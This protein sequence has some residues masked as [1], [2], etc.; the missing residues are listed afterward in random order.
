MA[1]RF[2]VGGSGNWSDTAHWSA[3][4]GGAGGVSVPGGA[5]DVFF[6]A[7]SGTGTA[8]V[9]AAR[10]ID[11]LDC[12]GYTGA[13]SVSGGSITA[14]G[15]ADVFKLAAGMTWSNSAGVDINVS[16]GTITLTCAGKDFGPLNKLGTGG[17]TFADA[18]TT[19]GTVTHSAGTITTG[20][21]NHS[22]SH[23][24]STGAT[25]RTITC[26]SSGKLTISGSWTVS[27]SNWSI[28]CAAGSYTLEWTAALAT[29][30]AGGFNYSGTSNNITLTIPTPLANTISGANSQFGPVVVANGSALTSGG[31]TI[32]N[33]MVFRK[34]TWTGC[35]QT[36]TLTGV[37]LTISDTTTPLVVSGISAS[38]RFR[39]LNGTL[40]M[41]A[42]GTGP[43]I[44]V[45]YVNVDNNTVTRWNVGD[46]TKATCGST[47][48]GTTPNWMIEWCATPS[49]SLGI[50][51]TM[52]QGLAIAVAKSDDLGL[53]DSME[54]SPGQTRVLTDALGITDVI[55][56]GRGLAITDALGI[57]DVGLA[58]LDD[59]DTVGITD[60]IATHLYRTIEDALG[61][62]DV[63]IPYRGAI[64]ISDNLGITDSMEQS[65]AFVRTVTDSLG[66]TDT[67]VV[68]HLDP[69]NVVTVK[70]NID[71]VGWVSKAVLR[72]NGTAWESINRARF[73]YWNGSAW[74]QVP[75]N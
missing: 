66:L 24:S 4:S 38:Q 45:D 36:L 28:T 68:F 42:G 26:G 32:S 75:A 58:E 23:Y 39:I 31:I 69:A 61:I 22:F 5:D 10:I 74:V 57:T 67:Q 65:T 63:S 41:Q 13:I 30:A 8:T 72:W 1:N 18:F 33:S 73:K 2:W 9:D 21:S 49:D 17:V 62:T 50:T 64:T 71:G 60:E 6:D 48:T 11:S 52:T 47:R 34:L 40:L 51:D 53:T 35:Q 7:N 12:T 15:T 46:I 14:N 3:S 55:D 37:T 56:F 29:W 59:L 43:V 25:T 54:A 70:V 16:A 20:T 44:S 19:T 27:G